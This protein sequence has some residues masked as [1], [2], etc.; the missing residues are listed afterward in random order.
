[1]KPLIIFKSKTGNTIRIVEAIAKVLEA[2]ILPVEDAIPKN[3]K[4]RNLIGF[5]SGIYYTKIDKKIYEL[6]A[7]L[8]KSCNTFMFVTSGMGF[9]FM[10]RL[11]WYF[12]KTNFDR[13]GVNLTGIWDCRGFDQHPLL[14]WMGL[15][16]R[17]PDSDD[18]KSAEQFAMKMKTYR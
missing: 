16:K 10:L 14:K 13:I 8:P 2:D 3:L 9:N 7:S 1:M 17:H 4:D 11:Y 12:I 18:V 5:G 15:S 6:A